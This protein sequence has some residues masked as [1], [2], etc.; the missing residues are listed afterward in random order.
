MTVYR[1]FIYKKW[2]RIIIIVIRRKEEAWLRAFKSGDLMDRVLPTIK[3]AMN[4][5]LIWQEP[6]HESAASAY[7]CDGNGKLFVQYII[8]FF[9]NVISFFRKGRRWP[10]GGT[11]FHRFIGSTK[12]KSGVRWQ[13]LRR[14]GKKT[15]WWHN[16]SNFYREKNDRC[17]SHNVLLGTLTT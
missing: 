10:S 6:R 16:K 8:F 7:V 9:S 5:S 12:Q 15:I 2:Y 1:E 3:R 17:V 13:Q 4:G 14:S 11:D